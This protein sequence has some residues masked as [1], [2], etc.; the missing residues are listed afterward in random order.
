MNSELIK[1]DL[2]VHTPASSDYRGDRTDKG[3]LDL[4]RQMRENKVI[5]IAVTDHNTLN[6]CRAIARLRDSTKANYEL[7]S[8][9]TGIDDFLKQLTEENQLLQSVSVI[10]GVEISFSHGV[11][12][13][14]LFN[15]TIPIEKIESFM[16]SRLLLD[17][18]ALETGDPEFQSQISPALA[19]EYATADFG[20]D[21]FVILP[22]ADSSKGA[23]KDLQG[24]TRI[25]LFKRQEV[26]AAQIV[27][28]DSR[29]RISE[30]LKQPD[31]K[32]ATGLRF[33]QA[34][35]YHGDALD[36]AINQYPPDLLRQLVSDGKMD[37]L[38][39]CP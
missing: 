22:H 20:E 4:F 17:K 24:Q 23:F 29:E 8:T 18:K 14:F 26:L 6:G 9:R 30:L 15:E 2:H 39:P 16:V 11:H 19:V 33:V 25:D 35:D 3:Y 32:R 27:N 31:Y 21:F 12:I 10:H 34:S 7:N 38:T 28:P 13:I 36:A 37:S 5:V 1:V